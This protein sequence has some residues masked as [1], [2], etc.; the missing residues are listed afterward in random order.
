MLMAP[1][2]V[3][4]TYSRYQW[5]V[6]HAIGTCIEQMST[7]DG[8]KDGSSSLST[9]STTSD[10]NAKGAGKMAMDQASSSSSSVEKTA[11]A[12]TRTAI[13]ANED[14][15]INNNAELN[16]PTKFWAAW[17]A[18]K[19]HDCLDGDGSNSKKGCNCFEGLGSVM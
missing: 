1:N 13:A 14:T 18:R 8:K 19:Q 10:A 15:K 11:S 4:C 16:D 5:Y 2:A 7:G 3:N 17:S 6:P 12:G 9:P